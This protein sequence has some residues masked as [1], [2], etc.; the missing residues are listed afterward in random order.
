MW[1]LMSR[2]NCNTGK[3]TAKTDDAAGEY[4][5]LTL[6]QIDPSTKYNRK[7]IAMIGINI[8]MVGIYSS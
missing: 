6:A 3:Y 7:L 2:A 8:E 4:S 5:K 1:L